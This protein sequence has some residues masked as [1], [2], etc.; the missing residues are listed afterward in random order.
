[1]ALIVALTIGLGR[2][3]T[4]ALGAAGPRTPVAWRRSLRD[5]RDR[6]TAATPLGAMLAISAL[7]ATVTLVVLWLVDP[8]VIPTGPLAPGNEHNPR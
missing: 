1:M 2:V 6:R 4:R 8:A 5:G 3:Q 7:L